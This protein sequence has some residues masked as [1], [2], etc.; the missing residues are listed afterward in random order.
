MHLIIAHAVRGATRNGAHV[1]D[2]GWGRLVP[3]DQC[4]GRPPARARLL[5]AKPPVQT[6]CKLQRS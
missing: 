6:R 5:S 3:A 1:M 4:E 2:A